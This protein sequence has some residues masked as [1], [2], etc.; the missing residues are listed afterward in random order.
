MTDVI[1]SNHR[2]K[3][4]HAALGEASLDGCFNIIGSSSG[5]QRCARG[6]Q[7]EDGLAVNG[8]E[9]SVKE[10]LIIQKSKGPQ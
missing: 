8:Q 10:G 7:S 1:Q 5:G 3:D 2:F 9:D 6:T 4:Q